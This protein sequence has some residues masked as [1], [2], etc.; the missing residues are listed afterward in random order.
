MCIKNQPYRLSAV[1]LACVLFAFSCLGAAAPLSDRSSADG[2]VVH[3]GVLAFR[4]KPETIKQWQPFVDYLNAKGLKK[5]VVLDAYTYKELSEAIGAKRTDLVLTQPAHYIELSYKQGLYSPL[6]TL[7]ERDGDVILPN[8]GGV[9]LTLASR[10]DIRELADLRGKRIALAEKISLGG[11][12]AQANELLK[13]GIELPRDAT[14]VETGVPHDNAVVALLAGKAD[15]AFVR[16]GVIEAM[17]REH[18]LDPSS[19]VVLKAAD[20]PPYPLKL[21]TRL[22]P[23]WALAAMPWLDE[24]VARQ[25]AGAVLSLPHGGEVAKAAHIEGFTIPGNYKLIDELMRTLRIPPFDAAREITL[26]DLWHQYADAIAVVSL[27]F[28]MIPLLLLVALLRSQAQSRQ[29]QLQLDKYREN[30]ENLVAER[31]SELALAKQAAETA[32][33]AKSTFLANM[34]HEIRTPLN[35]ITGMAYLLR[36]GGVSPEQRERLEKIDI[37]G[38]HLLEIINAILDLSKIEA[39]KLALEEVE[40]N[41]DAILANTVS[42]LIERAH[43]KHLELFV[44]AQPQPAHLLGDP[45]RLQQ[46]ILN[47]A[48]N[49]IKFTKS[50]S[51]K[52]R[53]AFVEDN[54][55]S[56]LI[57][58]E[59]QDTGVGIA[60]ENVAKL[61]TAFEQA[62][63]SITR[64]NGGTGLGLAIT[65]KL[66][67]AMGGDAGVVTAPDA[68][69]TFWFSARLKK[70]GRDGQASEAATN[71]LAEEVLR[72]AHGQCRI[73]LVE[74]EPVNREVSLD[75]LHDVWSQVDVAENGFEAVAK[76]KQNAYDLILMDMQMPKMDGVEATRQIRLLPNC[77]TTPVIAMTANAFVEDK[78]R[79]FEAGMNDFIAKP[80]DPELLFATLLKWLAMPSD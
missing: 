17:A 16:T 73:L 6:A 58:F 13:L 3:F 72:R 40:V 29:E 53:A 48:N 55:E 56:V 43:A 38:R 57:R 27:S 62:D 52:I 50:G 60:A 70:G 75:L 47:Y 68:G 30:L 12:M 77:A 78:A 35:A 41:V 5:K 4:P 76:V 37:A 7:V 19:I 64:E 2:G 44:E 66:A 28:G 15:A 63:N 18:R 31:T 54:P 36:R 25:I 9:I 8:F 69:S 33:I 11:F 51:V 59:V 26:A 14:L 79:C 65:K 49:A 45:T 22:Y 20:T 74:D 23:Q 67:L 1:L 24:E 21:S 42:M 61:F 80:V 71:V 34:S 32:N 10:N 46:A 39:G